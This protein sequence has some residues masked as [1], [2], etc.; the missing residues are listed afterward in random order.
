MSSAFHVLYTQYLTAQVFICTVYFGRF[1][2]CFLQEVRVRLYTPDINLEKA[3]SSQIKPL[4]LH[5]HTWAILKEVYK[6]KGFCFVLF[7]IYFHWHLSWKRVVKQ[8]ERE[9][10]KGWVGCWGC[11]RVCVY[12]WVCVY[13][14]ARMH[15]CRVRLPSGGH[16]L[17]LLKYNKGERQQEREIRKRKGGK[18]IEKKNVK[19][20]KITA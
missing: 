12:V 15:V 4:R 11:M 3:N 10:K 17:F 19:K 5:G 18:N 16:N 7:A 6:P 14:C 8:G 20:K 2:D 1:W 13:V 9:E